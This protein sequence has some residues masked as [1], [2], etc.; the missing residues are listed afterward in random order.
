MAT[1]TLS[2]VIGGGGGHIIPASFVL[3][4]MVG[5]SS[6]NIQ[7]ATWHGLS[8]TAATTGT[9]LVEVLN[10]S[11]SG[12]I[13]GLFLLSTVTTSSPSK[14]KI[15][16]DGVTVVDESALSTAVAS[17]W[18]AVGGLFAG[19]S[20]EDDAHMVFFEDVTFNSSLVVSQAGDGSDAVVTLYSRYLT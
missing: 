8:K 1:K 5:S 2:Q 3:R 12:V 11:G 14:W 18:C 6:E 4:K 20:A 19:S 15:V 10:I 7:A 17:A 16:I 13:Q 9:T